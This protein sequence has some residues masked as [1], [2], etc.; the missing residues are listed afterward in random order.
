MLQAAIKNIAGIQMREMGGYG[1]TL[2]INNLRESDAES[3]PPS[4]S[5]NST[6]PIT[7]WGSAAPGSDGGSGLSP[8]R[9]APPW[10][11][12]QGCWTGIPAS[13]G[14]GQMSYEPF[15]PA[16]LQTRPPTPLQSAAY[17]SPRDRGAV[18]ISSDG[19]F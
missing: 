13:F 19:D 4:C 10:S 14:T 3:S 11:H 8:V 12:R 16:G 6:L 5:L 9:L 7:P 2:E 15:I 1:D 18:S 17:G